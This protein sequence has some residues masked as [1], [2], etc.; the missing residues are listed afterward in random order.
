MTELE[1]LRK[2]LAEA[3]AEIDALRL[4]L[5]N[6]TF[7]YKA[8]LTKSGKLTKPTRDDPNAPPV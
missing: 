3:K 2:Q 6:A 1:T 5:S 4:Q 7:L 8:E